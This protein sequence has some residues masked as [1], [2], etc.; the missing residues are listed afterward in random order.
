VRLDGASGQLAAE[1]PDALTEPGQPR[2]ERAVPP[3]LARA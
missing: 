1:F 2:H 3:I